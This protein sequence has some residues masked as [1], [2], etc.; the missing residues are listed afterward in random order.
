[1]VIKFFVAQ[2]YFKVKCRSRKP[3]C[4]A[5]KQQKRT[6][7]TLPTFKCHATSNVIRT[8]KLL[9]RFFYE[10]FFTDDGQIVNIDFS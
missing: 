4:S 1:M 9:N 2:N 8:Q 5:S 10:R 6:V 3:V 7:L